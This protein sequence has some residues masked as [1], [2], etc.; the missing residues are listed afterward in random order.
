[1][2]LAEIISLVEANAVKWIA[3]LVSLFIIIRAGERVKRVVDAV[4]QGIVRDAIADYKFYCMMIAYGMAAS[5]QSLTDVATAMGWM[6]V[7]ALGKIALP[8][9]VAVIAFVN[10]ARS[11]GT[12]PQK[13]QV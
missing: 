10:N 6:T 13:T 7:A 11:N 4:E 8:G 3:V 1:M 2:T 9:I 5:L 12:V